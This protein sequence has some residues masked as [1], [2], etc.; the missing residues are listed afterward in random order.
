YPWPSPPPARPALPARGS[1]G[2]ASTAGLRRAGRHPGRSR[3]SSPWFLSACG[4]PSLR[5]HLRKST[6]DILPPRVVETRVSARQK[7]VGA[8]ALELVETPLPLGSELVVRQSGVE[9]VGVQVEAPL[10]G[11]PVAEHGDQWTGHE[12]TRHL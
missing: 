12:V 6:L 7:L 9:I 8:L 4:G 2:H 10:A 11:A 5:R 3:K 1:R